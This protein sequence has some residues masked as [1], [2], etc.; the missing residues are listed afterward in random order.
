MTTDGEAN[1]IYWGN[2]Q[3]PGVEYVVGDEKGI[4]PNAWGE[5]IVLHT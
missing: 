5:P 2:Q 3:T 1:A 4:T